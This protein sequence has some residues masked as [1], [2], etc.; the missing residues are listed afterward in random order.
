MPSHGWPCDDLRVI[1]LLFVVVLLVVLAFFGA[2]LTRRIG[3]DP[4]CEAVSSTPGIELPERP[5]AKA[6]ADVRFDTALRGYRVDQVDEVLDRLQ[7]RLTEQE[8]ELARLRADCR[9]E[10]HTAGRVGPDGS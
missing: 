3:Y 8:Q 10:D 4:L 1:W 2:L 5:D 6:V 9:D 7:Q